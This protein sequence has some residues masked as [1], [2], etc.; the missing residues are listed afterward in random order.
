MPGYLA[1]IDDKGYHFVLLVPGYLAIIDD[2]GYHCVTGA[3]IACYNTCLNYRGL[4]VRFPAETETSLHSIQTGSVGP[5]S[6]L[7][8]ASFPRGK[9]AGA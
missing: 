8:N 1:I 9:A 7:F 2:K 3:S 6:C 5:P 4:V